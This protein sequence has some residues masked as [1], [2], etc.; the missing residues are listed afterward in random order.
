LLIGVRKI[1]AEFVSYLCLDVSK[2]I[3]GIILIEH[4]GRSWVIR[5][6]L[7]GEKNAIVNV[8]PVDFPEIRST[9]H[10]VLSSSCYVLYHIVAHAAE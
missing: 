2:G 3:S 6:L 10:Q 5:V 1:I 4:S 8:E 9:C 7:G